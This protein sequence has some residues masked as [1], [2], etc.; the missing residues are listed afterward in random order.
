MIPSQAVIPQARVKKVIVYRSGMAQFNDVTT[1][2]R[3]SARIQITAGLN[4]G[5]TVVLTGLLSIR[6]EGKLKINRI[7][8]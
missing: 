1:G 6:P 2:V 4:P 8:N 3:D 7:V 5:D